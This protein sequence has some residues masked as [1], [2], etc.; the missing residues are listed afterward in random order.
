VRRQVCK[1]VQ[2]RIA[3]LGLSGAEEYRRFLERR[4]EEWPVLDS[5][6]RIPI[7]R[8]FRDRRVFEALEREVLP[9]LAREKAAIRAWSAGCASGEEPYSLELLWELRVRS[10]FPH[11]S[12][13]ITASDSDA[14]L[15]ERA[16]RAVYA[17]SSLREVPSDIRSA[18][19]VQ[20]DGAYQLRP[21]LTHGI[22]FRCEDLRRALPPGPFDLVLCR[23][24]AFTYFDPA[25]Q[26]EILARIRERLSSGGVLII[27][28]HESLPGA[29]PAF[30]RSELAREIH[31]RL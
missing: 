9:E 19:F 5:L 4:S 12:L 31:R 24:L 23:N 16:R 1:R 27:G 30:A 11:V 29:D 26:L 10:Q 8:F 2:R 22:D 18:A 21:E 3:A 17:P 28:A 7:S 20:I 13:H 6:C 25:L 14:G 15:L